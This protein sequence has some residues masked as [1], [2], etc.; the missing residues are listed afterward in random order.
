MD[1]QTRLT[2]KTIL[3][4]ALQG[5]MLAAIASVGIFIFYTDHET[6]EHLQEF[7]WKM[8]IL[9]SGLILFA[10]LCNGFRIFIISRSLGYKLSYIQSLSISLS[11]EFGI[12]A[13]PAG[14]G[15]AAIRLTL[16]RK[17]G[18]PL[19]HGT[20]MLTT[21]V[22]VDTIFF[23]MLVPFAIFA[24]SNNAKLRSAFGTINTATIIIATLLLIGVLF[25]LLLFR[26]ARWFHALYH[27]FTHIAYLQ[28]Y[29]LSGRG[30]WFK[31]F[32]FREF[33]LVKEGI[34]HLIQVKRGALFLSFIAACLQWTCRYSI[35]PLLFFS[36]NKPGDPI[37]L[38]MLQGFLFTASLLFVVPG[39]GGGVEVTA[40]IVLRHI[41]PPSLVGFVILL[42]RFFTFHLYLLGGGSMF[43]WTC[44]R[45]NHLFPD[46]PEKDD[47]QE[48]T[49]SESNGT[50]IEKPSHP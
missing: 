22:A 50:S 24:L 10:W 46:T 28:R 49:F 35:L 18:V 23:V 8:S 19:A 42:W 32:C 34:M 48:I 26:N 40:A 31:W 21:D 2:K 27:H 11:S 15:G 39:G 41:I 1:Q 38:F 43:F 5:A 9:L 29:R 47:T 16:L 25:L 20:S 3:R 6:F 36:L 30:R 45:M 37:L 4:Y 33:M 12:A 13:T 14:M 7:P 17:A 44:A